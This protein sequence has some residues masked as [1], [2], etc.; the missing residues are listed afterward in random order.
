[1]TRIWTGTAS[2]IAGY[3]TVTVISGDP[4]SD[5]NC[6]T[7]A[8]ISLDGRAMFVEA[9]TDTL[10]FELTS[11]WEGNDGTFTLEIDPM[12]PKALEMVSVSTRITDYEARLALIDG[13]NRGLWF[14]SLGN[15]AAND[16]GPGKVGR[17]AAA[18]PDST[19]A[20]FDVLDQNGQDVSGI[21]GLLA[22]GDILIG[23]SLD[24]NAVVQMLLTDA[25]V[26]EGGWFSAQFT[27][28][29][30]TGVIADGDA[31]TFD[32]KLAGTGLDY[33]VRV[34]TIPARSAYDGESVG[35]KVLVEDI[36]E[37]PVRSAIYT[38]LENGSPAVWSPPAYITGAQGAQGDKGWAPTF[39]MA[40]DGNRRVLQLVGYVGG[41][42]TE[43]TANVN[44]YV[45]AAGYT[46]TIGDAIDV[47]GAVGAQ[48]V[49]PGPQGDK[50]WAPVFSLTSDGARRVLQLSSYVGGAGSTPTANIGEYVGAAG[51]TATIGDAVDVRGATGAPGLDGS[52]GSAFIKVRVVDTTGGS[53]PD[54]QYEAGDV[55]DGVTLD[56]NNKVLR[57]SPGGDL[58]D[59]IYVV[60]ASGPAS[61]DSAFDTYD[62][63]PGVYISVMEGTSGADTLWRCTSDEGGTLGTTALTFEQFV[64]DTS[65]IEADLDAAQ[66]DILYQYLL[67][68]DISSTVIG[69]SRG[70]ADA[71]DGETIVDT[72]ASTNEVYDATND[73]YG[74]TSVVGA[75][76]LPV[77]MTSNTAPSPLVASASKSESGV[78][79]WK[80]FDGDASTFWGSGLGS[81]TE[82]AKV[83]LG[84]GNAVTVASYS[85]QASPATM[86]LM[87]K[88]FTYEGSNDDAAWNVLDT[89]A[90]Q[91]GWTTGQVRSF[92][93]A[94]VSAAYRYHRIRPTAGNTSGEYHIAGLQAYG[95]ATFSNMTLISNA[96]AAPAN[97]GLAR[98]FLA[99][100]YAGSLT[101]GTDFD[102]AISA[103]DGAAYVTGTATLWGPSSGNLKL[104]QVT[105]ID[106]TAQADDAV[107]ARFRTLT[108]KDIKVTGWVPKW[109]D[110]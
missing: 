38:L 77:N 30:S 1:M 32:Y 20:Y 86:A 24:S 88:D 110:A 34:E 99:L 15:T 47:R 58:L 103:N 80:L 42:G 51:Y 28:L 29:G 97:V 81:S 37:V 48:S 106:L 45:G 82:W 64:T 4:L 91:T 49:V 84:A 44:E 59:G 14:K 83:D 10:S 109:K 18:W 27:V 85:L 96:V 39:A 73:W 67:T 17:N 90:G 108:N 101:P 57:A 54:S 76:R 93:L 7:D 79:P 95:P 33:D 46:P 26:S 98:A 3:T 2:V 60:P 104:Y 41:E 25:M 53:S 36:G 12:T 68:A 87:I 13:N 102:F 63:H 6:P 89:R 74:P 107:R 9:R 50:G 43:P 55:L 35:T 70:W 65:E 21:L 92:T 11:P 78:G 100:E 71:F 72:G 23:R 40:S 66:A 69:F 105:G 19:A 62:E 52:G 94:A 22:A 75:A 5:A 61:R 31:V 8:R 56:E 16:P